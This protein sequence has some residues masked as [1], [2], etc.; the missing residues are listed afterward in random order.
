MKKRTFTLAA[1]AL[2]AA[3]G[4]AGCAQANQP[5][6]KVVDATANSTIQ[7]AAPS[8]AMAVTSTSFSNGKSFNKDQVFS[9][10]GCTGNNVSP[11][12]SW[13]HVP[14]GTK[15]F[16]VTMF[17]PD[18]PTG[19]GWWH[20]MVINIPANVTSLPAGAGAKNSTTLPTGAMQIT[21]NFGYKGFGGACPPANAKPHHYEITVY[22]LNVPKIDVPANAIPPL[23]GYYMHS[24]I[25]G[26][27]QLI[28]PTSMR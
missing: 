9:G 15:S 28:A 26:E 25:I 4:L 1:T 17:D 13:S 7:L 19:S 24:H 10:W 27:A 16:A 14:A 2:V 8:T 18:A 5:A 23:V 12:L 21:N 3:L 6:A 11:E 22:A 20:W